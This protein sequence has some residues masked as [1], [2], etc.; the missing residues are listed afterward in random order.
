MAAIAGTPSRRAQAQTASQIFT[1]EELL[2]TAKVFALYAY[3]MRKL[4]K[5]LKANGV[6]MTQPIQVH[7]F[8]IAPHPDK[9]GELTVTALPD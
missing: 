5:K 4:L 2:V 9:P 1:K 7:G 6:P 8:E 3:L